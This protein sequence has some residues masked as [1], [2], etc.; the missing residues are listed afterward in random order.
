MQLHISNGKLK[1]IPDA[2][3]MYNLA[4]DTSFFSVAS[5]KTALERYEPK[6]RHEQALK[7]ATLTFVLANPDFYKRSLKT[8]HTTASAWIVDTNNEHVLLTHHAKLD[9]WMQLG[10]HIETDRDIQSAALREAREESGLISL[11]L[12]SPAIFDIDIHEIPESPKADVHLH[13]DLRFLFTAD[14]EEPLSISD[15]SHSLEWC[16]NDDVCIKTTERSVL[17]MLEKSIGRQI[18]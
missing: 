8:G 7:I 17:R 2:F 4:V 18:G 5:V 10:G 15:E 6:N 14:R 1:D 9:R 12:V 16:A 13:Y 11:K 3:V